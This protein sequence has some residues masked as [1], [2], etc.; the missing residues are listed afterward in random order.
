MN[1]ERQKHAVMDWMDRKKNVP[2]Y[3]ENSAEGKARC[4]KKS[5]NYHRLPFRSYQ[6]IELGGRG[7]C[8]GGFV[9]CFCVTLEPEPRYFLTGGPVRQPYSYTRFLAPIDCSKIRTQFSLWTSHF[10]NNIGLTFT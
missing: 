1:P 2:L 4:L 3:G 8:W 5:S 10:I 7:G 9:T 6:L